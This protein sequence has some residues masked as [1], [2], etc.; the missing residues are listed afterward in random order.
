MPRTI[1][2]MIGSGAENA[3]LENGS[4]KSLMALLIAL[5]GIKGMAQTWQ[6]V[7]SE[8][9][10]RK[11]WQWEQ[12]DRPA[13]ELRRDVSTAS[14]AETLKV[15]GV[16]AGRG[17]YSALGPKGKADVDAEM[18]RA[19]ELGVGGLQNF[20]VTLGASK[21]GGATGTGPL[22]YRAAQSLIMNRLESTLSGIAF[23]D[24]DNPDSV[25]AQQIKAV[26]DAYKTNPEALSETIWNSTLA[27][28]QGSKDPVS[29]IVYEALKG[30][31]AMSAAIMGKAKTVSA[32]KD[33]ED[34]TP[35]EKTLATNARSK[36]ADVSLCLRRLS[37]VEIQTSSLQA[38]TYPQALSPLG[39]R[40][41][42]RSICLVL[43]ASQ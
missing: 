10:S 27:Q 37:R 25:K 24:A 3:A 11:R 1:G 43:T 21:A 13:E 20:L 2:E 34:A 39:K 18:E 22:D 8:S 33:K 28:R 6:A 26:R 14:A 35:E 16:L 19:G 29:S 31:K 42:T 12:A 30:D 4:N 41:K 9:R 23:K 7:E 15:S 38:K 36:A 5:Q 17:G 40:A 32:M